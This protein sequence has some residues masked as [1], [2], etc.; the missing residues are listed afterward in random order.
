MHV[1]SRQNKL[2]HGPF[3]GVHIWP[4]G[5]DGGNTG[6]RSNQSPAS[7][8]AACTRKPGEAAKLDTAGSSLDQ[9]RRK[10]VSFARGRFGGT[11]ALL[12]FSLSLS[13]CLSLSLSLSQS[14]EK[15]TIPNC[16]WPACH[17]LRPFGPPW[18]AAPQDAAILLLPGGPNTGCLLSWRGRR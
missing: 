16:R 11:V 6:V 3:L 4:T 12:F 2:C 8:S 18:P 9:R 7:A 15:S 5:I 14:P 13:L 17:C 10:K 1:S